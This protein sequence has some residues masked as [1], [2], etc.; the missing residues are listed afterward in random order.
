MLSSRWILATCPAILLLVKVISSNLLASINLTVALQAATS[1]L[2]ITS[3][4][5][6]ISSISSAGPVANS[7][8]SELL[9]SLALAGIYLP[10]RRAWSISRSKFS[11]WLNFSRIR[12][13]LHTKTS[14][15]YQGGPRQA[16]R[17]RHLGP[18]TTLMSLE[19]TRSLTQTSTTTSSSATVEAMSACLPSMVAC[20]V[21]TRASARKMMSHM[22]STTTML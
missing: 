2:Q 16:F 1:S 3:N 11:V 21:E 4:C 20:W 8:S 15:G 6:R 18:I 5:S 22:V 9:I 17:C 13:V 19:G 14:R 12:A 10:L 7:L